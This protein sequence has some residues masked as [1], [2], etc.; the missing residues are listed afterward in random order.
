MFSRTSAMNRLQSIC[1]EP[2]TVPVTT[3]RSASRTRPKVEP[4]S[5]RPY[6]ELTANNTLYDRHFKSRSLSATAGAQDTIDSET[7]RADLRALIT[8][9]ENANKPAAQN[10]TSVIAGLETL[11]G[12][13]KDAAV[14]RSR[15]KTG[16]TQ[17][18]L[19][20]YA[21]YL[22]DV[23]LEGEEV[24]SFCRGASSPKSCAEAFG[25]GPISWEAI[26]CAVESVVDS[27]HQDTALWLAEINHMEPDLCCNNEDN[28]ALSYLLIKREC[29]R[30]P[31]RV[32]TSLHTS[33]RGR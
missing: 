8:R 10:I 2:S 26:Q 3:Q 25:K 11:D 1:S 7:A 27:V 29:S 12:C 30:P 16:L 14:E 5:W 18:L 19:R 31:A 9:I 17:G 15:S 20:S 4:A 28:R 23:V 33:T 6:L 32:A 13:I 24:K 21:P 22:A